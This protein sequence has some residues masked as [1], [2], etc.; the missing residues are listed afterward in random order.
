[1]QGVILDIETTGHRPEQDSIFQIAAVAVD[2]CTG[3]HNDHF[4]IHLHQE[5][6]TVPAYIRKLTGVRC[7]DLIHAPLPEHALRQLASFTADAECV[8]AH[9]ARQY[10][11]P[12]LKMACLRHGIAV[13]DVDAWD[14][15]DLSVRLW[16]SKVR[17]DLD[18]VLQRLGISTHGVRRHDARH[19]ALLLAEALR[20]MLGLLNVTDPFTG[21]PSFAGVLP[22]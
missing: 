13:R 18:S 3:F 21:K 5:W 15:I 20:R 6:T 22:C 17:H 4:V 12:F 2:L 7:D 10:E 16:G 8:I 9:N 19:D 14:T 11:I 1:M